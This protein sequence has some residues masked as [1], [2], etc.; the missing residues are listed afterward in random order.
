VA[1][2]SP[3]GGVGKTMVAAGLALVLG[4]H[5]RPMGA[6]LVDL[7]AAGGDAAAILGCQE[8]RSLLEWLRAEQAGD[9]AAAEQ[10]VIHPAG[11]RVL[12]APPRLVDEGAVTQAVAQGVLDA[13]GERGGP[14]VAD[15][16]ST[17]RDSTLVAMERAKWVLLVVTP[18]LLAVRAARKFTQDLPCLHLDESR[19]RLVVNRLSR[20][21]D[22][23]LEEILDLVPLPLAGTLPSSPAVAGAVNR[24]ELAQAV[25]QGEFGRGLAALAAAVAP[26]LFAPGQDGPAVIPGWWGR[27]L[28]PLRGAQP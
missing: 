14:V 20:R 22:V 17:L 26:S 8:R 18:D 4:R 6:W 9:P 1:V 21:G 28:R 11:L 10:L 16:G 5:N 2:F 27:L 24:G 7:A 13:L 15:L 25:T 12:P 3:K 19:F 23:G